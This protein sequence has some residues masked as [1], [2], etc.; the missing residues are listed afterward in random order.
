MGVKMITLWRFAD[1][2][3]VLG[4]L[5]SLVWA[6]LAL[7]TDTDQPMRTLDFK[8]AHLVYQCY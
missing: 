2:G 7:A 4:R 5:N 8:K 3:L 6:H 1:G